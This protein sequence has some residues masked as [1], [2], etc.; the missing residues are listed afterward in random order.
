MHNFYVAQ[1]DTPGKFLVWGIPA[2]L[3][4]QLIEMWSL[5]FTA[6]TLC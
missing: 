6:I 4:G 2:P 3:P 1:S 5:L